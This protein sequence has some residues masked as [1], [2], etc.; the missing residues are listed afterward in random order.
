MYDASSI[1]RPINQNW[2][3]CIETIGATRRLRTAAQVR[4]GH[5]CSCDAPCVWCSIRL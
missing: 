3:Y 2:Q 1:R 4:R 5:C